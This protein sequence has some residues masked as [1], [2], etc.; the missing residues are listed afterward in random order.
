MKSHKNIDS[1]KIKIDEKSYKNIFFYQLGCVTVKNL[2]CLT[3]NNAS[4][5][6]LF[7]HKINGSIQETNGYEYL[8]LAPTDKSNDIFKKDEEIWN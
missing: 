4:P 6:R 8:T 7:T 1:N 5:L 2:T 3:V